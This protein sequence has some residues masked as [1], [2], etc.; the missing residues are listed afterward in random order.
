MLYELSPK[1]F[2]LSVM[3]FIG[4]IKVEAKDECAVKDKSAALNAR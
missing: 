2:P 3:L 1:L 4:D